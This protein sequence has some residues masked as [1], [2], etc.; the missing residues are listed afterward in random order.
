VEE[1]VS[2]LKKHFKLPEITYQEMTETANIQAKTKFKLS[3][4]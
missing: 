1:D 4:E 2:E 3:L